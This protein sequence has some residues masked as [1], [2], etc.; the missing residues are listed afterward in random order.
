MTML[1]TKDLTRSWEN[2]SIDQVLDTVP[3]HGPADPGKINKH[4]RPC[5]GVSLRNSK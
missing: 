5:A 2:L 3:A 1:V 4:N